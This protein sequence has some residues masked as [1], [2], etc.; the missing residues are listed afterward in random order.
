[1]VDTHFAKALNAILD[2]DEASGT[3]AQF[4][5]KAKEILIQFVGEW[6]DELQDGMTNGMSD[7]VVFLRENFKAL[8][9][10]GTGPEMGMMVSAMGTDTIMNYVTKAYQQ[11]RERKEQLKAAKA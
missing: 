5:E 4:V 2:F 8:I 3:D 9:Q 6:I 1:V 7:V 11:Y 10:A